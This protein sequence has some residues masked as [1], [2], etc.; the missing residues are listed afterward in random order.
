MILYGKVLDLS[1]SPIP[2]LVLEIW[3]T[4]ASGVYDHPGDPGTETRDKSFQFFGSTTTDVEGNF[5]FR[6]LKPGQYEPRPPHIHWKVK[7][8]GV[9][10]LTSQFY[11]TE[12]Q[13]GSPGDPLVIQLES[14]TDP[15]GRPVLLAQKDIVI[16]TGTGSLAPTPAQAEGPYYPLVDLDS[17]DNDLLILD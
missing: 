2:D 1:G 12:D 3:Q 14:G 4:D 11:F 17:F 16:N 5:A 15:N 9:E 6:T 8:G 10:L 7:M 13:V